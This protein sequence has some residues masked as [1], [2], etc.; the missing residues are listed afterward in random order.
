[1]NGSKEINSATISKLQTKADV[2]ALE[3]FN[4]ENKMNKNSYILNKDGTLN[5]NFEEKNFHINQKAKNNYQTFF[6]RIKENRNINVNKTP[7]VNQAYNNFNYLSNSPI[8]NIKG[9]QHVTPV[10]PIFNI[11]SYTNGN[12]K[13]INIAKNMKNVSNSLLMLNASENNN[14]CNNNNFNGNGGYYNNR[15]NE[16]FE[17]GCS[18]I[19]QHN[20]I[21]GHANNYD[22]NKLKQD[23][24]DS[25]HNTFSYS[26]NFR[27]GDVSPKV[28]FNSNFF[29]SIKEDNNGFEYDYNVMNNINNMNNTD[30]NSIYN[31]NNNSNI[32]NNNDFLRNNPR[33]NLASSLSSPRSLYNEIFSNNNNN[34]N[35]SSCN[36]INNV[37][38]FNLN[39]ENQ[40]YPPLNKNNNS[41]DELGELINNRDFG[42]LMNGDLSI[43]GDNTSINYNNNNSFNNVNNID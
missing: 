6:D 38:Y 22:I 18:N 26:N 20:S 5:N 34:S 25:Y 33:F 31:M 17:S 21:I 23:L 19:S 40:E 12:S 16:S 1:M 37:P 43:F 11:K 8:N 2:K 24:G 41:I 36:N 9:V 32:N 29:E 13:N 39:S 10:K 15:V 35:S 14:Y 27:S 7:V 30:S 28:G 3:Y 42:D 4:E